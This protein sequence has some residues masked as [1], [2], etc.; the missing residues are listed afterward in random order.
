M[1]KKIGFILLLCIGNFFFSFSQNKKSIVTTK[2]SESITIDAELNEESWKNA[3][4]ASDFVSFEPING[5]PIPN[6][7]KT[8]VKV[9]YSD[10]AIYIG[11][12]LYD[13]NPNKILLYFCH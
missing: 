12:T 13:P 5:S 9:V 4:I 11:A 10:N 6:E 7:F 1:T 2:I 8:E 3:A